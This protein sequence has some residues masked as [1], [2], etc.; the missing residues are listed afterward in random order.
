MLQVST[1]RGSSEEDGRR[2][3]FV[4]TESSV[5][6]SLYF[7][8]ESASSGL[9]LFGAPSGNWGRAVSGVG[10]G[11]ESPSFSLGLKGGPSL[12]CWNIWDIPPRFRT[13]SSL[14]SLRLPLGILLSFFILSSIPLPSPSFPLLGYK[15]GIEWETC[16]QSKE[17]VFRLRQ[18]ACFSEI[19]DI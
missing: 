18:V 5:G 9:I 7:V 19:E 16:H 14:S 11:E 4:T 8:L 10:V 17:P 15:F 3:P 1:C 6:P 13:T 2:L 12:L